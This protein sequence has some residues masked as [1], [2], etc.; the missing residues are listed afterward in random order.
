MIFGG[1]GTGI[2]SILTVALVGLFITGL[3]IGRTPEY[4]GK[5]LNPS[6]MKLLALYLLIGPIG[7][8]L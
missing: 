1:L 3:M 5:N 2:Y 7:I 4:L 8:L 6:E